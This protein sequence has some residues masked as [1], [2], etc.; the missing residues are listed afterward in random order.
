MKF[1]Q[2]IMAIHSKFPNHPHLIT[3]KIKSN[4][5]NLLYRVTFSD[6]KINS[7]K[8]VEGIWISK[9]ILK[10]IEIYTE[11]L[12]QRVCLL[13]TRRISIDGCSKKTCVIC[14]YNL[15]ISVCLHFHAILVFDGSSHWL[16][17]PWFLR[18]FSSSWVSLCRIQFCVHSIFS[19]L[20]M[21]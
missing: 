16:K 12:V 9:P 7:S 4:H 3:S 18:S 5:S 8:L 1:G 2:H 11:M 10:Y 15:H 21:I 6:G 19:S 13:S 17:M 20:C 14:S